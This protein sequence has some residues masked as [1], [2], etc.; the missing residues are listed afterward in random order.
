M[1]WVQRQ[2]T[3]RICCRASYG[4]TAVHFSLEDHERK[5]PRMNAAPTLAAERLKE[6]DDVKRALHE[7]SPERT[8]PKVETKDRLWFG[9]YLMLL[10]GIG[11][12]CSCDAGNCGGRTGGEND[13]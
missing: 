8:P 1:R 3:T 6:A 10:L 2:K 9:S 7:V 4:D 11:A 5:W 13:G 12:C